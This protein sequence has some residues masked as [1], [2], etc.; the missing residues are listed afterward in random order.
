M[1]LTPVVDRFGPFGANS[2]YG[3]HFRCSVDCTAQIQ[4]QRVPDRKVVGRITGKALAGV[5]SVVRLPRLKLTPGVHRFVVS[6]SAPVNPGTTVTKTKHR[7]LR[8]LAFGPWRASTSRTAST[9][10]DLG[11]G[12]FPSRREAGKEA[13]AEV[14]E[15]WAERLEAARVLGHG[16]QA[17]HGLLPLA[18]HVPL[19]GSRRARLGAERISLVAGSTRRTRLAT[20]KR[21]STQA[22]R[23]RRSRRRASPT[24]SSIP[25]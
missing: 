23:P 19:R 20:T 7:V 5:Y 11:G 4:L 13:F 8:S 2:R 6:F 22:R 12:S 18:D 16:C 3:V 17:R 25:S 1:K 24:S 10:P 15:S 9:G 14:V 21:R